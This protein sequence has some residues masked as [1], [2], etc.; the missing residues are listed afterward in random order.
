MASYYHSSST[1]DNPKHQSCPIGADSWCWVRKAEAQN[2]TPASHS[3]KDMW[4][5]NLS[6]PLLAEILKIYIDLTSPELMRRC[7]KRRTQN[8]NES[9]HSQ[10]WLQCSKEKF[11]SMN[12]VRMIAQGTALNHNF[13][14]VEGNLPRALGAGTRQLLK[15]LRTAE[16]AVNNFRPKQKAKRS[17]ADPDASYG[18][19]NF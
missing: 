7:M 4:L 8:S 9:L 5:G 17:S 19:G 1:D 12:R 13:G 11:A 15:V 10:I 2:V 16:K 18:A 6:Q 14:H 3:S